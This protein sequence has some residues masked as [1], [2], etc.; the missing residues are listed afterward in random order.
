MTTSAGLLVLWNSASKS[1]QTHV[2]MQNSSAFATSLDSPKR[3]IFSFS[4][5]FT[6]RANQRWAAGL[7]ETRRPWSGPA[8]KR[9]RKSHH[10]AL[11]C[12]YLDDVCSRYWSPDSWES[13]SGGYSAV[14]KATVSCLVISQ[15]PEFTRENVILSDHDVSTHSE[16]TGDIPRPTWL[17]TDI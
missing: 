2:R 15:K 8:L 16:F 10:S 5:K 9:A 6:E 14:T 1:M 13:E 11:A 7:R 12:T 17:A 4:G 3:K